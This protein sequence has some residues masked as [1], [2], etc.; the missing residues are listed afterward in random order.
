MQFSTSKN[1]ALKGLS[2]SAFTLMAM[3]ASSYTLAQSCPELS[4]VKAENVNG[5]VQYSVDEWRG[6]N[7]DT[8]AEPENVNYAA[9]K[10]VKFAGVMLAQR[11]AG[12]HGEDPADT[13]GSIISFVKCD[14]TGEG[15][16]HRVRLSH[17]TSTMAIA[18]A[19]SWADEKK[20]TSGDNTNSAG[21]INKECK[22]TSVTSCTFTLP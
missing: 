16:N 13:P 8:G 12:S 4:S 1:K 17:R 11:K 20:T 22:A 21:T 6:T 14:Y 9:V 2:L 15:T 3:M 5:I 19:G 10:G 18:D 7:A